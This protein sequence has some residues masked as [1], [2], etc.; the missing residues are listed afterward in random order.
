MM[1]TARRL[2]FCRFPHRILLWESG[3]I[4]AENGETVLFLEDFRQ[5]RQTLM[6]KI[7][8]S[9][10]AK[11]KCVCDTPETTGLPVAAF[12]STEEM[13]R[14]QEKCCML[15]PYMTVIRDRLV[16]TCYTTAG[17]GNG[18]V[19]HTRRRSL[20]LYAEKRRKRTA[21]LEKRTVIFLG[22]RNDDDW[23]LNSLCG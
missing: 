13:I 4:R 1:M 3:E 9:R 22:I 10:F 18:Q 15:F 12:T 5:R 2:F 16:T 23:I 20:R 14:K 8:R 17:S 7:M 11:G 6:G 21:P 19:W